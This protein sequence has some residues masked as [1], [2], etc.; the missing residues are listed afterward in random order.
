MQDGTVAP[1]ELAITLGMLNPRSWQDAARAADDLGFGAVFVSDHLVAPAGPAGLLDGRD[2]SA[3]MK[4]D[5]P[6]YDSLGYLQYLAG[7]T[8]RVRLGTYVYLAAL[9]HPFATARAVATLDR[10]SGGRALLGVGAGWLRSEFEAAQV[11]WA[12]RGSRLEEAVA[13][14]RRLWREELVE[15]RGEFWEFPPVGF[16][17]KPLAADGVPVLFGGE[18][19]VAV[20]RAARYGD[21]WMG[22]GGHTPAS[23]AK[24]VARLRELR[25]PDA[26]PFEVTV[27]GTVETPGDLEAWAAAGVDRVVVA[28]WS[29]SRTAVADLKDFAGSVG[30]S[31]RRSSSPSG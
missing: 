10:V 25:G 15:H 14:C 11:P 24:T 19:D 5:T 2:E 13:V 30:L 4:P 22:M 17:P 28:P 29:S 3:R 8:E 6:L 20:A 18:S 9:R 16:A 21:G 12:R 31:G 26:G 7:L 27:G 1:V 23:A